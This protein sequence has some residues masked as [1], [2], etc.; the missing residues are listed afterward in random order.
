MQ[1]EKL[2]PYR[3]KAITED[4]EVTVGVLAAESE[5]HL[6]LRLQEMGQTLIKSKKISKKKSFLNKLL[7]A[8]IT[9]KD[10]LKL[11]IQVQQMYRAGIPLLDALSHARYNNQ[12]QSL[13]DVANEVYKKVKEGLSLSEAMSQSPSVFGNLEVSIVSSS[14]K[15]GRMDDALLYVIDHLK[16]TDGIQRRMKKATRY[17]IILASVLLVSII[18]MMTYVVPQIAGLVLTIGGGD[19]PIYTRA[20]IATSN[21]FVHGWWI[22]LIIVT[23]PFIVVSAIRYLSTDLSYYLDMVMLQIPVL[24]ELVRKIE[25]ARFASVL[26]SLYTA[27]ISIND[28]LQET[29]GVIDNMVVRKSIVTAR[30]SVL[31]GATLSEALNQTGQISGTVV[32]MLKVGEESGNVRESLDYISEFFKDDADDTIEAAL[33]MIEPA[34]T[35]VMGSFVLWII[36]AVFGPVYS[37]FETIDF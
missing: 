28:A 30:Q 14:E 23:L 20:L 36:I 3:Y 26:G 35:V 34:L 19:L 33:T 15:T 13:N 31:H 37:M 18:I 10:K 16:A 6:F 17:P 11:Y 12:N 9:I 27:G 4:G 2:T 5:N 1:D 21:F 22:I 25:I 8:K 29:E 32:Q 7:P 24:G